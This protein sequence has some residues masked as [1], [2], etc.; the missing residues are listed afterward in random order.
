MD[1]I[2]IGIFGNVFLTGGTGLLGSELVHQLLT[3]KECKKIVC[4]VRDLTPKSRFFSEKMNE[5]VILI[6]GDLRDQNL[7][8]RVLNEYE[9][10]TIFHLAAQTLVGQANLRPVD[11]LDVNIRGTWGLLEA[12]RMNSKF[13]KAILIASS[14]KAYGNLKG[15]RYDENFPLAGEHP[16]DVSKSC[17][18]LICQMFAKTYGM[19]IGITRCGNFFGP[20]DLNE[21][22]IFPST[23]LSIL[24][25][26]SPQIRSDGKYIRDYIFVSD[27]A[28]AYRTLARKLIQNPEKLKGEA[29]NFSYEL[30]LTV[31]EV[32]N[33]ILKA[34]GSSL[35]PTILNQA[36]HE[37]P[38]QSLDSTKAIKFLNWKPDFGFEEGVKRTVQWYQREFKNE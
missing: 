29:F 13:I 26:E 9:I 38:V 2:E 23:I 4:L 28:S 32:V 19:P 8:D 7:L 30:K 14:D 1:Q 6:Q 22:R 35:K 18:D 10:N 5:K 16:Y 37:I 25:N 27:G 20:G 21:S 31:L 12:A 34:A 3:S 17:M 24:K 36:Q 11:T 15:E 33:S